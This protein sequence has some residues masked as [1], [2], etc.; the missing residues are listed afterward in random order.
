MEVVISAKED[1]REL[2]RVKTS[3]EETEKLL[4]YKTFALVY[5][6]PNIANLAAVHLLWPFCPFFSHLDWLYD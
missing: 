3:R 1:T 4:S 6:K 5:S 2:E